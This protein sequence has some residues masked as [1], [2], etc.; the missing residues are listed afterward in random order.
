MTITEIGYLLIA[1]SLVIFM[2]QWRQLLYCAIFFSAFS[3]T[4]LLNI[5]SLT[6]G[7]T[8]YIYFA[9]LYC[10]AG[11]LTGGYRAMQKTAPFRDTVLVGLAGFALIALL[12]TIVAGADGRAGLGYVTQS[13]YLY[14]GVIMTAVVAYSLGDPDIRRKSF[15]AFRYGGIFVATWGILQLLMGYAGIEYPS[16]IFN[17]SV[18]DFA[19]L[20]DQKLAG[21]VHRI[22][23][24]SVEPS[25]LAFSLVHVFAFSSTRMAWGGAAARR[26][27]L[28][29]VLITGAC[30]MLS[31]STTAYVGLLVCA[32]IL[33]IAQPVRMTILGAIVAL[34]GMLM[35]LYFSG[36]ATVLDEVTLSKLDTWSF[37]DRFANTQ[38][39]WETFLQRPVLGSGWG[40]AQDS[41]PALLL[42][43]AG[44]IGF[45]IFIATISWTL[46]GMAKVLAVRPDSRSQELWLDCAGCQ[47]ALYASLAM[48]VASGFK[49]V[50]FD[51]WFMWGASIA[52]VTALYWLAEPGR[53]RNRS[54]RGEFGWNP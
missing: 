43:N 38:H 9:V 26:V 49:Y 53:V 29:A 54:L 4:S 17:N 25:F 8:P 11:L 39:N 15:T 37:R 32:V 36:F 3:A 50:V 20:F 44:L 33:M 19:G 42:A 41:L 5:D 2:R 34:L 12:A 23:S 24:V 16:W 7:V 46:F 1:V 18:S 31:T 13:A 27:E 21:G 51:F 22:S 28:P 40:S 48:S 30:L 14:L 52:T 45:V 10:A 47:T 35:L 6:F